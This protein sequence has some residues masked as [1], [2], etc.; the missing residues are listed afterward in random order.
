MPR[1][2][3]ACP[4]RTARRPLL[5]AAVA[6][7][8][9]L[10]VLPATAASAGGRPFTTTLTGA[11]EA[12]GPGDDN[13]SGRATLT[14]NPGQGEVCYR[15]SATGVDTLLAGHIHEAPVGS[16]GPVVVPLF[17][18]QTGSQLSGCVTVSRALAREILPSPSDYYV[19]V[20]NAEFPAG[21]LRAS[22]AA[23]PFPCAAPRGA[24]HGEDRRSLGTPQGV[25]VNP[26]R[27]EGLL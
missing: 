1:P 21:A 6:S 3:H 22:S 23:D 25:H 4:A 18:A 7:A 15:I 2:A 17:S 19:N 24:A 5:A 16:A 27:T 14:I 12:P 8:A 13:G 20:H 26:G 10:A 9:L 11:A